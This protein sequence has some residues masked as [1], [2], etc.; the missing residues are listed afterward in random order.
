M[1]SDVGFIF[2]T[3]LF[4]WILSGCSQPS[5][6]FTNQEETSFEALPSVPAGKAR[7]VLI[8]DQ[9]P[10]TW[11]I[12]PMVFSVD[13]KLALEIRSIR[14]FA[15]IDV[16]PGVR[17]MHFGWGPYTELLKPLVFDFRPQATGYFLVS[18][19]RGLSE[20]HVMGGRSTEIEVTEISATEAARLIGND[21]R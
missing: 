16:E 21:S 19:V 2:L 3:S 20:P 8:F 13:H 18:S 6:K 14:R 17:T 10:K 12:F 7:L 9:S 15:V 1:K 4:L 5:S 11:R